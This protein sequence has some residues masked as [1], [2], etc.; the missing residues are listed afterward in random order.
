MDKIRREAIVV[1][2]HKDEFEGFGEAIQGDDAAIA[3]TR[4][5]LKVKLAEAEKSI[6]ALKKFHGKDTGFWSTENQHI[7]GHTLYVPPISVGGGS[8]SR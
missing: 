5:K 6:A 1:D 7:L 4:E 8:C 2:H 3:D